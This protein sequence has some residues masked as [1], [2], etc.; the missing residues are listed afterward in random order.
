MGPVFMQGYSQMEVANTTI[1]FT[2]AQHGAALEKNDLEKFKSCGMPILIS[3]VRIVDEQGRE[4][5]AGETGELITRGPHMMKGY[6][7]KEK[8]TA[9]A[10]IDGWLHTGDIA[11]RDD[12]GY[13]YLVDRKN[14][15][16]ISG[17]MNVYSTEVENV[18]S[19]HPAV[20]EAMVIGIPDEKWGEIV[21]GII[22]KA[23][24]RDASEVE[25]LEFCREQL[26]SYKRPKR[27]EFYTSLP[28]TPYGKLDKK[29]VRKKYWEGMERMI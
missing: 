2:K 8:E 12:D 10:I 17:G 14:D 22:V 4:V 3:Q 16:I 5:G 18:L 20:A 26:S 6:W 25:L 29:V 11:Y 23:Q 28:K 27:I 7:N 9:K 1:T 21:T 15:M 24:G 19:R 13:V